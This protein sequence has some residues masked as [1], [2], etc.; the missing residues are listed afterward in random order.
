M[1]APAPE[2]AA[3]PGAGSS[4]PAA[5]SAATPALGSRRLRRRV[6]QA[7]VGAVR[8]LAAQDEEPVDSPV[9]GRPAPG[10]ESRRERHAV[11]GLRGHVRLVLGM[12]RAN[13]PWA[14]VHE[15]VPRP[16]G[17]LRHHGRRVNQLHDLAGRHRSRHLA[18]DA[19]RRAV[20]PRPHRVD[21][22]R[23]PAVGTRPPAAT[24][25][26]RCRGAIA[27]ASSPTGS[28]TCCFPVRSS[29]SA[30]SV[31]PSYR[32]RT[33]PPNSRCCR[34]VR[35]MAPGPPESPRQ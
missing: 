21:H 33:P 32:W 25:S 29:N 16:G 4:L 10:E 27:P 34:T 7:V 19:P 12:V 20:H 17:R 9:V 23:P 11:P 8:Q 22:H 2:S 3:P 5:S 26:R 15:P 31:A 28:S 18:A 6:R 24:I 30:W 13:R 35:A 14:A 1:T